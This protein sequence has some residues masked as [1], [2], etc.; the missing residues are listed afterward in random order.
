[1]IKRSETGPQNLKPEAVYQP[2]QNIA[3]ASG[4]E[5]LHKGL[6]SHQFHLHSRF[7][8]RL[9]QELLGSKVS[10]SWVLGPGV[11]SRRPFPE[12]RNS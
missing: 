8:S 1:M 7:L 6:G 3:T 10:G 4:Q 2:C 5:T 12:R 11:L 9:E